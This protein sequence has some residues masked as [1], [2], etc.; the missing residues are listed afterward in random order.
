MKSWFGVAAGVSLQLSKGAKIKD[1][2][3]IRLKLG[4]IN[5]P[6]MAKFYPV[7]GLALGAGIQPGFM[8]SAKW[9]DLDYK[10]ACNTFDFSI[11]LSVAYEA[12]FGLV[13]KL[14]TM[15]V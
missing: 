10:D 4:Y 2:H 6:I 15:Q 11:P 3:S 5:I 14:A 1:Y 9:D 7:K 8:T 13:M 12:P